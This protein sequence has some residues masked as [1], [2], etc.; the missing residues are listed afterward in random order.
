[1]RFLTAL[2]A[3]CLPLAAIAADLPKVSDR[4]KKVHDAGLLFDGHNDLPWALR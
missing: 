1:M 2:F 3:L 4:A